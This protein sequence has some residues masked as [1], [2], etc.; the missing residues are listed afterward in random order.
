MR[1]PLLPLA[2]CLLVHVPLTASAE[3][4]D[5]SVELMHGRIIGYVP[6]AVVRPSGDTSVKD[7]SGAESIT[8]LDLRLAIG[9]LDVAFQP[10][11]LTVPDKNGPKVVGLHYEVLVVPFACPK[12]KEAEWDVPWKAP[13]V[14][15]GYA[16]RSEHN[17]DDST[18]GWTYANSVI[19]KIRVRSGHEGKTW[20]WLWAQWVPSSEE[21]PFALTEKTD[22]VSSRLEK[23][24]WVAGS[25][26]RLVIGEKGLLTGEAEIRGSSAGVASFGKRIGYSHA[27]DVSYAE[28]ASFTFRVGLEAGM[29]YNFRKQEELG[30]S[31]F[32][33]MVLV[34]LPLG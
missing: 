12:P 4:F 22:T 9:K 6:G 30:T 14:A 7:I 11:M 2:C 33:L 19:A 32:K 13:C 17:Q 20:T 21:T 25:S 31:A 28:N 3:G 23:R 29:E 26:S 18:F 5:H 8:A 24:L 15:I 1:L 27:L 10:F 34:A 16:H